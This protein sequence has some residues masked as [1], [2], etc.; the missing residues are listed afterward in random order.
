MGFVIVYLLAL[1]I[2][3][4]LS[5]M[6]NNRNRCLFVNDLFSR[7]HK[8]NKGIYEQ[9]MNKYKSKV[10]IG[11][12][13]Y[14]PVV[15]VFK[16][17]ISYD[18]M[19]KKVEKDP[20]FVSNLVAIDLK[21]AGFIFSMF[22]H[23]LGHYVKS[24]DLSLHDLIEKTSAILALFDETEILNEMVDFGDS[25]EDELNINED[26]SL[27]QGVIDEMTF[28]NKTFEQIELKKK[29]YLL[30]ESYTLSEVY[31]INESP[32]FVSNPNGTNIAFINATREEV[33]EFSKKGYVVKP[34]INSSY[35]IVSFKPFDKDKLRKSLLEIEYFKNS[36]NEIIVEDTLAAKKEKNRKRTL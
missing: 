34:D 1:A 32:I 18:N 9:V 23:L 2:S 26:G 7:G 3:N 28:A 31:R 29:F 20:A 25:D 10:K 24:C 14:I 15:C 13:D 27:S 21:D 19:L 8:I 22:P 33:N 11:I 4:V 36:V 16:S 5:S 17:I 6:V 30:S 12:L 35:R